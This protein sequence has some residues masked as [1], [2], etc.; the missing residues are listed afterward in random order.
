MKGESVR[1]RLVEEGFDLAREREIESLLPAA[2]GYA[3]TRARWKKAAFSGIEIDRFGHES[4]ATG[5][6]GV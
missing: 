5:L 3:G 6:S 2:N 1:S 4:P